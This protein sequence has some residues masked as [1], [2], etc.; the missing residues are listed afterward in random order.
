MPWKK[1]TGISYFQSTERLASEPEVRHPDCKSGVIVAKW[2]RY[3]PL[4]LSL[5]SSIGKNIRLLIGRS[6]FKSRMGHSIYRYGMT[7]T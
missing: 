6:G 3:P 1:T 5:I 4:A 2:V 7:S